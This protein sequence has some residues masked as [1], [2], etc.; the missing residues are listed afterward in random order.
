PRA[1]RPQWSRGH[2]GSTVRVC[3]RHAAHRCGLRPAACGV[4]RAV[5]ATLRAEGGRISRGT[6]GG[7]GRGAVHPARRPHPGQRR[8][9]RSSRIPATGARARALGEHRDRHRIRGA[10]GG[11]HPGRSGCCAGRA[12]PDVSHQQIRHAATKS[13]AYQVVHGAREWR[14]RE[15]NPRPTVLPQDFSGCSLLADFLGPSDHADKSLTGPVTLKLQTAQVTRT[16][17]SGSLD[18]ARNRV[19]S[20]PGLTDFYARSGGEGEVGAVVISTYWFARSVNEMTLHSRPASPETTTV[21]ET[22]H[23]PVEL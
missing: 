6:R 23:P 21:V 20:V 2:P 19:E 11:R 15:A 5:G 13:A 3:S 14:W 18:D 12:P 22:D 7:L 4:H 10:Y 9:L 8:R 16:A 1:A 17:C